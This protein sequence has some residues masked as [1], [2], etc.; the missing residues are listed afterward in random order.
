MSK[1]LVP[2]T[3]PTL[4]SDSPEAGAPART[5]PDVR[6]RATTRGDDQ[7]AGVRITKSFTRKRF[8]GRRRRWRL[9][10]HFDDSA[11]EHFRLR[12]DAQTRIAGGGHESVI[13][14][15]R[16]VGGADG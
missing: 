12:A 8:A 5:V 10:A 4:S 14:L 1:S 11:A 6:S 7:R 3:R 15:R 9:S 16:S 13:P 2:N